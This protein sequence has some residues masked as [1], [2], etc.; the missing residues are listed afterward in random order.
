MTRQAY[1]K[2]PLTG[3]W[4]W[5]YEDRGPAKVTYLR[6]A[7]LTPPSS[8]TASTNRGRKVTRS[9]GTA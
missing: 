5:T 2:D 3:R 8:K 4:E 7:N 9:G 1:V 6:G